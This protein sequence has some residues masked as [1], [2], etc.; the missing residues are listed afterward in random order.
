MKTL[1]N[2]CA[3]YISYNSSITREVSFKFIRIHSVDD[4][5]DFYEATQIFI[6]NY[7]SFGD[8]IERD[9][10]KIFLDAANKS[11]DKKMLPLKEKLEEYVNN[12]KIH[13]E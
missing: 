6:N 8:E 1:F 5:I 2:L 12:F 7:E 9:T 4:K 10:L 11:N 13:N 3:N